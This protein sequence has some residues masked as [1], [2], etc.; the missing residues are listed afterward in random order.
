MTKHFDSGVGGGSGDGKSRDEAETGIYERPAAGK[1]TER[2]G[3]LADAFEMY[4]SEGRSL[5]VSFENDRLNEIRQGESYGISIRA[6]KQGKIGFSYSSKPDEI[7][8]VAQSA[9]RMAPWGKPYDYQFAPKAESAHAREYDA[10]CNELSVE[11]MVELCDKVKDTIK[12]IDPEALVDAGINGGVSTTRIATSRG[13]D[14]R[15]E[16]SGFSYFVSARISEEGNFLSVYRARG[17]SR[18]IDDAEILAKAR[19]AAEEFK[20]ARTLLPFAKGKYRVLFAPQTVAD[21]LLPIAVGVNGMNIARKTSRFVDALNEQVFDPRISL[22]DDPFHPDSPAG[23]VYDGEGVPA[24]KRPIVE[25]GVLKGFVHTLSTAQKCG[26]APTGNGQRSVSSQPAP[27]LH[28]VVMAPGNAELADM[29]RDTEGGLCISQMLGTFTSNFLAGQVSGNISLGYA[30]K[31]GRCA[32]RVKNC[33]LNV[34][35]F[36]VLKGQ[37]V[38][39]SKQ[40]EWVGNSYLPWVLLDGIGISAR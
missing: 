15:E 6:V 9:V 1:F 2:L 21:L 14:C 20:M 10:A 8:H 16:D 4:K 3:S 31:E 34:N 24:Q 32:G 26:H 22:E 38:A 17:A 30:V 29:L 39:I 13:Q 7:D 12:A 5:S 36:D 23:A 33:A 28:S 18:V 40:R 27:G 19:E 25:R 37:I 11:H 35:S